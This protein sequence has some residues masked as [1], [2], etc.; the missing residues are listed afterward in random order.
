MY[1]FLLAAPFVVALAACQTTSDQNIATGA[2]TGAAVGA[3]ASDS[4]DRLEGAALGA[5][6]GAA[7][8]ALVSAANQPRTC[9][10]RY[11]NG[12]SYR[13]ECPAGY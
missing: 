13:A 9:I 3:I 2:L 10:Y 7:T 5:A 8:G 11:P 6:A 12:T 4:D 1:K